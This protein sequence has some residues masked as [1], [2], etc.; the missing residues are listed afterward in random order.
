LSELLRILRFAQTE[1]VLFVQSPQSLA[2]RI[3]VTAKDRK[4]TV[5]QMLKDCE[6]N[7]DLISTTQNKG[8]YPRV[9]A[10]LRIADYLDVSVDYLLGR[11]DK[12]EINR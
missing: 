1:G 9:D 10:L 4:I 5:A 3:K 11:T 12:P 2:E 7:K 6:L 8:Y